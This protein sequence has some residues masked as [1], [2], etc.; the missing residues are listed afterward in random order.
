MIKVI[1][2]DRIS[3]PY[4]AAC[5]VSDFDNEGLPSLEDEEEWQEWA[6]I[7][8]N[9]GIFLRASVP[10]PFIIKN[11]ARQERFKEWQDWAKVVYTIMSDEYNIPKISITERV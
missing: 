5:L 2:P 7:V 9:T 3:L 4:W 10:A 1:I 8:A 11:G 6:S